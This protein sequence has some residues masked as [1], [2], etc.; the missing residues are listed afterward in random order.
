M[1]MS[2]FDRFQRLNQK[3][4]EAQA[5]LGSH[6]IFKGYPS[7]KIQSDAD[8][9]LEIQAAVVNQ[10]EKDK[11]YIY[12]HL[13]DGLP[14]G[15][16]WNAKSLHWL[17][18]EEIVTIKDVNWHKYMSFLC[19]INIEDIWGY[20]KGPEKTY[21]NIEKDRDVSLESLQKPVLVLPEGYL[22]FGDKIV[23]KGRPWLVQEYDAISSP[24]IVYYSLRA[25]TVSKEVMDEHEGEDVF[26]EYNE[27]KTTSIPVEPE[28]SP[29]PGKAYVSN[30]MDITVS[31]EEGYFK[32]D[33][34]VKIKKHTATEVVFFLPFGIKEV[35]VLTKYQGE[36]ETRTYKVQEN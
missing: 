9:E 24:G 33:K 6:F 27:D 7:V 2:S 21:M 15:S 5:S 31:T 11:A 3:R 14:I 25:T 29:I 32:A 16:T 19:N 22:A 1:A 18:A 23:I 36:V 35:E 34:A 13:E 28:R 26:I 10:Q 8:E 20:F 4:Q 12:T 17:I 30:N